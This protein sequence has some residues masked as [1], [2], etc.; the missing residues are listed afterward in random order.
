MAICSR[1][2]T[3]CSLCSTLQHFA[4]L[5]STLQHFLALGSTLQHF[6]CSLF[7]AL[8]S[9]FSTCCCGDLAVSSPNQP[10]STQLHVNPVAPTQIFLSSWKQTNRIV[11]PLGKLARF[12]GG[13]SNIKAQNGCMG[14][15]WGEERGGNLDF[16]LLTRILGHSQKMT[17]SVR[18]A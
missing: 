9:S 18:Y 12:F 16:F 2:E 10:F 14:G 4:A 1:L 8:Y 5:C 13:L 11:K 15:I 3:L 6:C 7:V 17:R